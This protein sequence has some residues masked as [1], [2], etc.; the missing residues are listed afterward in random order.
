LA[1]VALLDANVLY[2]AYLRDAFLRLAEAEIYQVRWSRKILD[3]MARLIRRPGRQETLR[4]QQEQGGRPPQ[5]QGGP[6]RLRPRPPLRHG[7]P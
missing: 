7:G 5:A 6:G 4:L 3:E 1:F 2:P